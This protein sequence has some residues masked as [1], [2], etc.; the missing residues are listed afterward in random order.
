MTVAFLVVVAGMTVAKDDVGKIGGILAELNHSAVVDAI[1]T[2][3]GYPVKSVGLH[4][5]AGIVL[6]GRVILVSSG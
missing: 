1:G 3:R 6:H 2:A 4:G 5:R